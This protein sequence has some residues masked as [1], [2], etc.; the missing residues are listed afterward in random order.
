MHTLTYPSCLFFCKPSAP[1]CDS[2]VPTSTGALFPL[3]PGDCCQLPAQVQS[4]GRAVY[5]QVA[6]M[7]RV[8][9]PTLCRGAAGSTKCGCGCSSCHQLGPFRAVWP[10]GNCAG[11]LSRTGQEGWE[12]LQS[13]Q[14]QQCPP[15]QDQL[16]VPS[17]SSPASPL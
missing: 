16:P 6:W 2:P 13:L 8:Y 15:V 3:S 17:R 9:E 4:W 11:C 5:A 12:K 14:C 10:Q 7:C 1:S